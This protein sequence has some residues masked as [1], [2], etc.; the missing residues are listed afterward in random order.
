[1][2][3]DLRERDG[4]NILVL[5]GQLTLSAEGQLQEAVDTLLESGRN[6]ILLDFTDVSFMDS[7]GIGELVASHR[8]VESAGGVLKILKPSKRI[9]DSLSLT[10]LLPIFQV[11]DSE[12]TAVASFILAG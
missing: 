10:R 9:Q 2:E 11:F 4:V 6:R 5:S 7:V 3:L 1:M 8:K 12:D